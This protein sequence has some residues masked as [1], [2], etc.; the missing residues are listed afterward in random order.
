[1]Q[2]KKKTLEKLRNLINE[3]T[4]YRSG[5]QIVRFFNMLDFN[6]TY[7][8]G[9]PSRWIYTDEKLNQINGTPELDKCIKLLLDPSEFIGRISVL[10]EHIKDFNQYLA[11]DKWKI[12]RNDDVITFQ[13]TSRII[14]ND[15][16]LEPTGDEDAFLEKEFSEI[17]IQSLN[18]STQ[19]TSVLENRLSE[20][21][22]CLN[23]KS[24]LAVIFLSGS[25]LEGILLGIALN[26]P[27]KFNSAVSSTK[28]KTGK[29][30]PLHNW[31]LQQ[32]ID[33]ACEIGIIMEDVKKFSHSLRDF[34]N[35]IH[36]YQQVSTKFNPTMH[37]AKI[38][39]QVLKAAIAQTSSFTKMA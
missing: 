16:N 29:V 34:R 35:Y 14:L 22:T 39:F 33:T 18:L 30:K 17:S 32:L 15:D 6:D 9:F 28:D 1:M 2:L 38:C 20:I 27:Q 11:F 26:N 3:E 23:A 5:P 36:P 21:K 10:D 7:G 4:Q 13:K 37:T 24:P 8:Q 12:V 31:T 19:I 25:T